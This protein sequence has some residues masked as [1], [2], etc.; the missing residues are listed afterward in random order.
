MNKFNLFFC[1]A[2]IFSMFGCVNPTTNP[3]NPDLRVINDLEYYKISNIKFNNQLFTGLNEYLLPGEQTEYMKVEASAHVMLSYR[4]EHVNNANDNGET[5]TM[6]TEGDFEGFEE[7]QTYTI[8]ITG[9][10][11]VPTLY[12]YQ[13]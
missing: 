12:V 8:S 4:W 5:G 3:D 10:K 2:I 7:R 6:F 13:P 9:D 11:S 1:L